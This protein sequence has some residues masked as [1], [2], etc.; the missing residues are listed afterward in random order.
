ME[1]CGEVP[2]AA[3]S[4]LFGLSSYQCGFTASYEAALIAGKLDDVTNFEE[5][6]TVEFPHPTIPSMAPTHGPVQK[7]IVEEAEAA[8][9]KMRPSIIRS[10]IFM[11]C[12]SKRI[13]R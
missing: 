7:I 13:W 10:R 12:E 2:G 3:R 5:I 1:N 9:K 6:S 11:L 8:L 4:L